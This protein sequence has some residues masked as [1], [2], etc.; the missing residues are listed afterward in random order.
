MTSQSDPLSQRVERVK[1]SVRQLPT[2]AANLNSATDQLG[3]SVAQLDAVLKKFSLGVPTWVPFNQSSADSVPEYY[4]EEIG[5]AK[6][7][8][9]WGIA[10][11]TIEGT[12]Q[13]PDDDEVE[14]WLFNDAPRLLRVNAVEK[15]ADL[16]DALI[17]KAAEMTKTITQK[18]AEVDAL[19]AGIK[20]VVEPAFG[21]KASK[22]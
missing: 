16:L 10:I 8:G 1:N 11:R 17:E 18:T 19:A 7:G 4:R 14:Q 20:S 2:A 12:Y 15:I 6:V 21:P 3:A 22:R 13:S 5:Y 9:K